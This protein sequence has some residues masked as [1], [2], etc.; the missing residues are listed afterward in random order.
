MSRQ[1]VH[2]G[3]AGPLLRQAPAESAQSKGLPDAPGRESVDRL[4][5]MCH[6]VE[7]ITDTERTVP[8]WRDT[9]DLMKGYG[10]VATDDE[11]KTIADYIVANLALLDVNKATAEDIGAFFAVGEK[12]ATNVVAYRDKQGG[13]KAIEDL[14][15]APDLDGNKVDALK[16]RLI[17]QGN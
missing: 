2:A 12:V 11:W 7:Y 4:C 3:A 14:K 15:K 8:L 9:L 17:F 5:T 16:A 1:I 13:F 10:A 6:G